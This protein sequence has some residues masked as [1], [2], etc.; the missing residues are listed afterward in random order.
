MSS[1]AKG[2]L[3]CALTESV[4]EETIATLKIA[5]ALGCAA[6]NNDREWFPY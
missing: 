4:F 5:I 1:A 6:K 2:I 3:L